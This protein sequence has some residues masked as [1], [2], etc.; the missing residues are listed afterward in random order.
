MVL[1]A[2]FRFEIPRL[3]TARLVLRPLT[4]DDADQVF[5]YASDPEVA[6]WTTWEAHRT[7]D[8]SRDYLGRVM[9]WYDDGFGGPWGLVLKSTGQLI[10]TCGMALTPQHARAEL[11]YAIGRAWWGQGL[12]TEAVV[13]AIRYGFEELGLNRI[14]ARCLTYNIG[15]ARVM[16]KAGMTY[17]GTIREQVFYKGSFD[18]LKIYSILRREWMA[19]P[20]T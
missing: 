4:M 13:E 12:M 14:E 1:P 11:G 19:A 2:D 8:D 20:R 6:S 18:D 17:E 15:S 10:G 3:E 9:S 16:E 7:L 5:A